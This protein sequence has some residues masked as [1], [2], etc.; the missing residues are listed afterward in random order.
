MRVRDWL[1]GVLLLGTALVWAR[2]GRLAATARFHFGRPEWKGNPLEYQEFAPANGNRPGRDVAAGLKS[3]GGL[4]QRKSPDYDPPRTPIARRMTARSRV[5]RYRPGEEMFAVPGTW[6]FKDGIFEYRDAAGKLLQRF[7]AE[8][9]PGGEVVAFGDVEEIGRSR[10]LDRK[11]KRLHWV[12]EDYSRP[13]AM[14]EPRRY[15][16]E[17]ID[18]GG[19]GPLEF[20]RGN[21][22]WNGKELVLLGRPPESFRIPWR[23]SDAEPLVV[24]ASATHGVLRSVRTPLHPTDLCFQDHVFSGGQVTQYELRSPNSSR[25]LTA[26]W[27]LRGLSLVHP[28]LGSLMSHFTAGPRN[29]RDLRGR[30]WL[31]PYVAQR[32]QPLWCW[33]AFALGLVCASYAFRF[34][35]SQRAVWA[36]AAVCFG[37]VALAWLLL[38]VARSPRRV[39]ASARQSLPTLFGAHV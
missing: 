12:L 31:D 5:L 29:W 11:Q 1:L 26:R 23:L 14:G 34:A 22:I 32:A 25:A 17:K 16:V 30:L 38:S 35:P 36:L 28:P 24:R 21:I 2:T 8:T 19:S 4:L 39:P 10:L 9:R 33:L 3:D 7:G 6:T 18:I 20:L 15:R 13:I 27:A 37:L